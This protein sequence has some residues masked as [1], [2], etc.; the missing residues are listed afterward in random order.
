MSNVDQNIVRMVFDNRQFESGVKESLNTIERLKKSLNFTEATKSLQGLSDA[1]KRFSL[2]GIADGVKSISDAFSSMGIIGITTLSNLTNSAVNAGK[3][4]VTSLTV[5]PIK[6]G[7]GKYEQKTTAVKTIISATNL[8]LQAVNKELERLLWFSDETSYSFTDMVSNVGK[9]T[10]QGVALNTSVTAMQGIATWAALSGQN[11]SVASN[12]M[13]NMAQALGAGSVKMKDWMSIQNANMATKEFKETAIATAQA[14]GVLSKKGKF[15]GVKITAANFETTLNMGWFNKK[16]LLKTLDTYGKFADEVYAYSKKMGISAS[17]AM[18]EMSKGGGF[19]SIG[20]KAFRAAQEAKTLTDAINATKDA[21]STKWLVTSELIFGDYDE[22]VVLWTDFAGVLYDVFAAAGDVRNELLAGWKLLGGRTVLLEAVSAAWE[23][24]MTIIGTI[25]DAFNEI[26]PPATAENLFNITTAFKALVDYFKI[27]EESTVNLK[28]TFKG[29]FAG[30]DIVVMAFSALFDG[31]K[32]VVKYLMPATDGFL[33]FTGNIGDFILGVRDAIKATDFFGKTIDSIA[34]FLL[35]LGDMLKDLFGFLKEKISPIVKDIKLFGEAFKIAFI[36]A[37][38]FVP[39]DKIMEGFKKIESASSSVSKAVTELSDKIKDKLGPLADKLKVFGDEG[40]NGLGAFASTVS[41]KL[42]GVSQGFRDL[43]YDLSNGGFGKKLQS[44]LTPFAKIGEFLKN[45]FNSVCDAIKKAMPLFGLLADG[46]KDALKSLG[47]NLNEVFTGFNYK[48]FFAILTTGIGAAMVWN[49]NKFIK[50]LTTVKKGRIDEILQ[51]IGGVFESWQK[52]INAGAILKLAYAL[53]I[54]VAAI[55]VLSFIDPVKLAQALTTIAALGTGMM[56]SIKVYSKLKSKDFTGVM[57]ASVAMTALAVALLILSIGLTK[58]AKIEPAKLTQGMTAVLILMSSLILVTKQLQKTLSGD[59]KAGLGKSMLLAA[60][61][62][63]IFAYAVGKLAKTVEVLGK[64]DPNVIVKG[65][66]A[67][68]AIIAGLTLF[69]KYSKFEE[70][71]LSMGQGFALIAIG[72]IILAKAVDMLAKLE[73]TAI[74]Q[75]LISLGAILAMLGVFVKVLG[76]PANLLASAQG[77]A[78]IAV[79]IAILV[80]PI[81]ALSLMD[82]AKLATGLLALAVVLGILAVATQNMTTA[83]P[84]AGALVLV[85]VALNLL[86]PVLWSLGLMPWQVLVAGLVGLAG[87]FLV[88]GIAGLT[89]GPVVPIL[90]GLAAVIGILGLSFMA[91]GIGIVSFATG[92][93]ML[94]TVSAVG[95]TAIQALFQAFID[96]IPNF[97]KGIAQGIVDF[98]KIL[99][100]NAPK[101]A[102]SFLVIALSILA[103]LKEILPVLVELVVEFITKF[104]TELLLAAPKVYD[105]ALQMLT[106]MLNALADNVGKIIDAALNLILSFINGLT[107]GIIKYAQDIRVAIGKLGD[108]IVN[109]LFADTFI[110]D[111]LNAGGNIISTIISAFTATVKMVADIAAEGIKIGK[112]IINGAIDGIKNIG[113]K[114]AEMALEVFGDAVDWVKAFLGIKSPSRVFA[115]IGTMMGKGAIVG[116]DGMSTGVSDSAQGLGEAA[117]DSMT[118][119]IAQVADLL[120]TSGE[121][122]PV[123][124]PVIDMTDVDAGLN[125]MDKRLGETRTLSLSGVEANA[126]GAASTINT[127][128]GSGSSEPSPSG[129]NAAGN[130]YIFNQNNYSPKALSRLE[131]Y[132]QTK[133]QFSSLK[134]LVNGT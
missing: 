40:A 19:K 125:S 123:I 20:E 66:G 6:A 72:I 56:A 45:V 111:L 12:A 44:S 124:T 51:S 103:T 100:D 117:V 28:R 49:I 102:N 110:Q 42:G 1:G 25:S 26:F 131:I 69:M 87:V 93:G 16:V 4:L 63:I 105:A 59:G 132:R 78:L 7:W 36:E 133:N 65:L 76:N 91:I 119:A 46:A 127:A 92:I 10:A 27:G 58:L 8:P 113:W 50:N 126:L 99:E 62:L 85:A 77:I 81:V 68:A 18:K 95:I 90:W 64:L 60:A 106:G 47:K 13:Y 38:T 17:E 32:R 104:V 53:A 74:T 14:L 22:A 121:F 120:D 89:L 39:A 43:E 73:P 134:G 83:I 114:I 75:G 128:T 86:V 88:L 112:A 109:V 82:P 23:N 35:P 79:A 101:I 70:I 37:F 21:V 129:T 48:T 80:P 130:S 30:V 31:I 5:D 108:A 84:G 55:V 2:G 3:R 67:L 96:L 61:S 29:L 122:A 115:E 11:A 24:M 107:A 9:F 15:K 52:N 98:M 116:L 34:A 54:L 71:D 97:L 57:A 33:S 41:E 94:A 118:S